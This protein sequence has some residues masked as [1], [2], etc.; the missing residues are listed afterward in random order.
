M[1]RSWGLKPPARAITLCGLTFSRI[2]LNRSKFAPIQGLGRCPKRRVIPIQRDADGRRARIAF[3]LC[4]CSL[5]SSARRHPTEPHP[6]IASTHVAMPYSPYELYTTAHMAS[7][8]PQRTVVR[9]YESPR[10]AK[11]SRIRG[12][13]AKRNSIFEG[14]AE[15]AETSPRLCVLGLGSIPCRFHMTAMRMRHGAWL[16]VHS[17]TDTVDCCTVQ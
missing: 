8:R 10:C 6:I 2:Y 14:T 5:P 13:H 16:P 11:R 17:T 7:G 12:T 3:V 1:I 4:P 9:A 15:T